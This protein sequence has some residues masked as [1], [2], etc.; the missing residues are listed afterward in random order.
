MAEMD[1]RRFLLAGLGLLAAPAIVRSIPMSPQ[2]HLSRGE[3][4]P[5]GWH[6]RFNTIM[7][8]TYFGDSVLMRIQSD[9]CG[10]WCE[11]MAGIRP[12]IDESRSLLARDLSRWAER[13]GNSIVRQAMRDH[14]HCGRLIVPRVPLNA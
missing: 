4:V 5:V 1:R 8:G 2:F 12:S 13:E 9:N 11:A 6:L 3:F 10:V 14:R 7:H